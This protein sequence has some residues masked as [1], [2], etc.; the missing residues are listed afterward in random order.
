MRLRISL[1]LLIFTTILTSC[2]TTRNNTGF[3]GRFD[4]YP[5]SSL[6]T[7]NSGSNLKNVALSLKM[8]NEPNVP[9]NNENHELQT[10]N[11]AVSALQKKGSAGGSIKSKLGAFTMK[12]AENSVSTVKSDRKKLVQKIK[13]I[14]PDSRSRWDYWLLFLILAVSL[15]WTIGWF[16]NLSVYRDWGI[17]FGIVGIIQ[18]LVTL[19]AIKSYKRMLQCGF[20]FGFGLWASV[21][22]WW[23]FFIPLALWLIISLFC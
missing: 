11:L 13:S 12:P 20:L 17:V 1:L 5:Q 3:G 18:A 22:F 23:F 19:A 4:G 14:L 16:S 21:I 15:I 10:I 8:S 9:Q 7:A 6:S 2:F